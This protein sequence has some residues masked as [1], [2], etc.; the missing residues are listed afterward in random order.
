MLPF[1]GAVLYVLFFHPKALPLGWWY[2]ATSWRGLLSCFCFCC[3]MFPVWVVE[4]PSS[5]LKLAVSQLY[6]QPNGT[7][8]E[9]TMPPCVYAEWLSSPCKGS[10][11]VTSKDT[12]RYNLPHTL[13]ENGYTLLWMFL[14]C[15]AL[16]G[17]FIPRRCRQ[18]DGMLPLCGAVCCRV[19]VSA[20]VRF[21]FR[22]QRAV[23]LCSNWL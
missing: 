6:H 22:L 9:H 20:V 23:L 4:I 11:T 14:F 13:L 5:L 10:I 3:C 21:L 17:R 8:L 2:V 12:L 1:Q 16:S 7:A 15:D 19:F 18:V